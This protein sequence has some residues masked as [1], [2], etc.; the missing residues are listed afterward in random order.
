MYRSTAGRS[1]VLQVSG[2]SQ[3]EFVGSGPIRQPQSNYLRCFR[4]HCLTRVFKQRKS[5]KRDMKY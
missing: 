1:D 5:I 3:D 4:Y 2:L